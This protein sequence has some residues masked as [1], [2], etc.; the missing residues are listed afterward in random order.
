MVIEI[1]SI[2]Q[3]PHM[4]RFHVQNFGKIIK[5]RNNRKTNDIL[6]S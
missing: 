2:E 4:Q 5:K 1:K 6:H 3:K